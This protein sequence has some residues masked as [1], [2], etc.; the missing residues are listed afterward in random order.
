MIPVIT[1]SRTDG[2]IKDILKVLRK[3]LNTVVATE[4]DEVAQS[5]LSRK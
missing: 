3:A 2:V 4:F 5:I 1:E